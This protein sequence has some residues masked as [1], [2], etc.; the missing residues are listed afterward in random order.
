MPVKKTA[1]IVSV[2]AAIAL[3]TLT[4]CSGGST[5]T[6]TPAASE[7]AS[8][9]AV[10]LGLVTDGTLTAC[11]DVPYAPFEVED[12]STESGYSG[13]DIEI[14]DALAKKLG[15]T[16]KVVD[17][18]FNALQSG[19]VLAAGQCDMGA[20]AI[21]ITDERKANIDFTDP[22]YD[23]LQSLLVRADSGITD[24]A[25]TAGKNIGVQAGTTGKTYA[26]EN[27]PSDAKLIDYP[28]DGELWPAIQAGQIDAIL[29]DL[30]VNK[31]HEKADSNYKIVATFQT[32]EQ[33]GFALAKDKNPALLAA[34]N[35]Q[36]AAIKADGTYDKIY[37]SYFG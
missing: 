22:Y 30:P 26:E 16:L 17:V 7:S 24:L 27:A 33:Y 3:A 12:S 1:A 15:L 5:T 34:L 14:I 2:G 11:S 32:D 13:F 35:E 29:Q 9:T 8:A 10:D 23:S 4:A 20:S 19:A 25:G 28:S 37:N 21:T 6:E 18:D 31:E 36:L